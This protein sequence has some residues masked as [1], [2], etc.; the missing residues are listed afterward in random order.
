MKSR[1]QKPDHE[2]TKT[3]RR[4]I[5]GFRVFVTS[6]LPFSIFA[7]VVMATAQGRAIQP[8]PRAADFVLRNGKIVTLDNARADAQALAI[9][10][11]SI[12]AVGSNF[13]AGGAAAGAGDGDVC[14]SA[15]APKIKTQLAPMARRDVVDVVMASPR[16]SQP[17]VVF[18]IPDI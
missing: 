4:H 18:V 13:G 17:H 9:T 3:R 7:I 6:W 5:F 10:G 14:A 1:F 11:D 16:S 2:D 8:A 15:V 12:V